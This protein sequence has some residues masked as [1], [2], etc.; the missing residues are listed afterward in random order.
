MSSSDDTKDEKLLAD[1]QFEVI[2]Q[3]SEDELD[4]LI[5]ALLLPRS[6][7]GTPAD[8]IS[9]SQWTRAGRLEGLAR[10]TRPL[11]SGWKRSG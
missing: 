8:P 7:Q 4:A 6:V 11:D 2:P 9:M 3:P 5:A 1:L 10:R